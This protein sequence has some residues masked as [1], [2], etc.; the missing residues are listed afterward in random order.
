MKRLL[1]EKRLILTILRGCLLD[2]YPSMFQYL[3]F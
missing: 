3:Q 2:D 1:L